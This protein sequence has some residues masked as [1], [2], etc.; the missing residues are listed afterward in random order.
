MQGKEAM[1]VPTLPL[2]EVDKS[3]PVL[4]LTPVDVEA[5]TDELLAYH[6]EFADL[7]YRTEQAYWSHKYLQGLLLPIPR[8]SIQPMALA[9]EGGNS[10]AMQQFIGQG[11]W[12][13]D[14][15]LRKH[16]QL[17]DASLGEPDGVVIID[18]S[19]FPKQG[20]DSVG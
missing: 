16:W 1:D 17:V 14:C 2:I 8:K 3:P 15:L 10:Q 13:D 6:A 5:L 12:Q 18:G 19:D 4:D 20:H 7:Y 11:L 9:L